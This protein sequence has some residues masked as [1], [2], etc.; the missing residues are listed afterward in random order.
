M[1]V[2][3]VHVNRAPIDGKVIYLS[4]HY[5]EHLPAFLGD[6]RKNERVIAILETEI[7][8]V[9]LIQ[10]AGTFA[11]RVVSYIKKGE[12]VKK[13]ERIGIIK[14]GSRVDLYLPIEGVK[15]LCVKPKE[16]VRAGE[17]RIAEISY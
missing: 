1:N 2:W 8:K 4:H 14:F 3:N 13:G 17:D 9:K 15:R 12:R 5:G 7:G 10:I 11:R 6:S 16:R